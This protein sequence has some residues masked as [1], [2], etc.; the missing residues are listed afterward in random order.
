MDQLYDLYVTY[1]CRAVYDKSG[2]TF[3]EVRSVIDDLVFCHPERE[4]RNYRFSISYEYDDERLNV[5]DFLS[6]RMSD[7]LYSCRNPYVT[8]YE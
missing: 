4:W 7:Y 3:S 8:Q 2:L 6:E 5:Y 1:D